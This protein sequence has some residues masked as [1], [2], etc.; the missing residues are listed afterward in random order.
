LSAS[1]QSP[2]QQIT[3][4]GAGTGASDALVGFGLVDGTP[5]ID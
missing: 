1:R 3:G 2:K 5:E 4:T